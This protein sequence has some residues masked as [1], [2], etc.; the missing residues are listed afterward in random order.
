MCKDPKPGDNDPIN[1]ECDGGRFNA[2]ATHSL[3][4]TLWLMARRREEE[5]GG[6]NIKLSRCVLYDME[7]LRLD[8]AF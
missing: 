6:L 8:S 1:A 4:G 7:N 3:P 5:K 2:I